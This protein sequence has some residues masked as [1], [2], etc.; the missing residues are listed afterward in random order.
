METKIH[1]LSKKVMVFWRLVVVVKRRNQKSIPDWWGNQH[2]SFVVIN[3]RRISFFS[4]GH[5]TWQKE[6]M[7]QQIGFMSWD[8]SCSKGV[9][10][11]KFIAIAQRL[12]YSCQKRWLYAQSS[13][14][15]RSVSFSLERFPVCL[16]C[17]Q[18]SSGIKNFYVQVQ[19]LLEGRVRKESSLFLVFRTRAF[20]E[21]S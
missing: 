12:L 10:V 14:M 2:E 11:P 20:M 17:C 3:K 19:A 18:R 16:C 6:E 4:A 7:T 8:Q 1:N 5:P 13:R 9:E 21:V 15:T